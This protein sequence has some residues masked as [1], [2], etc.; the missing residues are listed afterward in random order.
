MNLRSPLSRA[1]GSGSAKHGTDHWWMQRVTAA[2]LVILGVWFL[3]AISS[4]PGL[5]HADMV[6]WVGRPLNSIMLVLFC[7]MLAW[8]SQLG[9]QVVVE[10][11]VHGPALKVVSLILNRFAHVFL[12]AAAIFAILNLA[13]RSPL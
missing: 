1:L 11:Y 12:V 10:D 2:A 7:V 5:A 8:H 9:I 6:L 13:F 4:L 3:A